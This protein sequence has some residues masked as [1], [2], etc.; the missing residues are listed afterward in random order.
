M[1]SLVPDTRIKAVRRFNRLY[2]RIIGALDAG[3]VHTPY[4]LAEARVLYELAQRDIT[5]VADLRRELDLDAGYLSRLLSQ[6]ASDGLVEKGKSAGDARKQTVRLTKEGIEAAGTLDQRA[7]EQIRE[8][9]DPMTES[10][11]HDLVDAMRVISDRIGERS[12][13][14][15]VVLRPPGPGDFGWVIQRH[16]AL[17]AHEFDWDNTFEAMV[18]RIVADYIENRDPVRDAGWIAEVDGRPVGCVFCVQAD[19]NTAKLRM[20]LVEPVARGLGVGSRLVDQCVRFATSAGY[21]TLTLWTNDV[22]VAA[23]RIYQRAG[24]R[25]VDE[26]PHHSFGHDLV[27]QTWRLDLPVTPAET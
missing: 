24:F 5:E 27:G 7:T 26:Q 23:R 20:L 13:T 19:E 12:G 4:S 8:L 25:L 15:A 21:R 10:D 9:L 17:Y 11:Q 16:G 3:L 1:T 18:A 2:T 22:L 6:L 14:S